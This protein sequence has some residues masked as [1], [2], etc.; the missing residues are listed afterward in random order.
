MSIE[1]LSGR[2]A[3]LEGRGEPEQGVG[4][5]LLLTEE[6]WRACDAG[7]SPSDGPSGGGGKQRDKGKKPQ[8]RPSGDGSGNKGDGGGKPPRREGKCNY[9]GIEGHWARECRKAK[10]ERG[11]RGKRD[12]Q[13]HL[14]Q[15]QEDA[16]ALLMA[17][18]ETVTTPDPAPATPVALVAMAEPQVDVEHVFLNEERVMPVPSVDD[19]SYLDTGAN[20]H[21]T[22]TRGMFT[23]LDERVTGTV[24]F[25]DG[26][27]VEIQGRGS[28]LFICKNSE[29]RV[30][31]DVYFI[32][33]LRSNIVSIGQLDEIGV[34]TM[35]DD[36][37]M[38]LFDRRHMVIARVR[39]MR[40]RLYSVYLTLTEPVSLLAQAGDEAW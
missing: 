19:R 35:V 22:G 15:G 12:D 3:A 29:H 6:E 26:S 7:R 1:E 11:D 31:T 37:I 10:R 40:N 27:V 33:R 20:N 14:V 30:L 2:L 32:P 24:K 38:T 17:M 36:G 34:R 21:M 4:G 9:C 28:V 13:A 18:V 16:P 5:Q 8:G 23:N 39:R 25:G